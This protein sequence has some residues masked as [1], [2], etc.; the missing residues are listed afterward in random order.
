MHAVSRDTEAFNKACVYLQL[1]E[2]SEVMGDDYDD[3]QEEQE[4]TGE[5]RLVPAD[6]QQ[7]G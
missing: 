6:E 2:G 5:L 3:E 4:L 1:D 7:G